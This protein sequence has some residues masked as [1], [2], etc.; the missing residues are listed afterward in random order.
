M[1][2]PV[3][4]VCNKDR[5]RQLLNQK[6]LDQLRDEITYHMLKGNELD[7]FDL[8]AFNRTYT[9]DMSVLMKMVE[10]IQTELI[11]LGWFTYLGFGDTGLY[12]YSTPE[13]PD[14]IY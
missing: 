11:E 6:H 3:L 4:H 9:K 5:F 2:S 12:I 1:F 7:F 14:G 10:Q 13:K 8:D